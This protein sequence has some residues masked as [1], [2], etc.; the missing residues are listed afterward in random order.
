VAEPRVIA[1]GRASEILDLGDGRLLRRFKA[2]GNPER[3]AL[4]MRH[5]HDR[6]YPVPH[7]FEVAPDG[8]VIEK[9]EGPTMLEAVFANP[10]TL[11]GQTRVLVDLHDR[12]HRIEAPAGLR[13]L[14]D[15]D[16]LLH[17]DLHPEN[18]ILGPAG[19]VVI[20]W[21]NACR[22]EGLLDVVYTWIIC[23]T[24]NGVGQL[25]RDFVDLFLAH[26]DRDELLRHIPLATEHRLA[27]P[28]VLDSE[29]ERIRELAAS[30]G[31]RG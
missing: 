20:D 12:L 13:S 4:V 27:D 22:G 16:R 29:R 30:A 31:R 11:V 21:A 24:S 26:F 23:A 2:G 1:E 17:L 6:D 7:V 15:G 8:L 25:G 10:S 3:E 9:I 28:N 18:V 19:P 5:A 14:G